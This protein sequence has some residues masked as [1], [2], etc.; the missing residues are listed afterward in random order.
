MRQVF[1]LILGISMLCMIP[2][3]KRYR[4]RFGMA[5][6]MLVFGAVAGCAG[7]PPGPNSGSGSI[8]ITGTGTGAAA[9]ITHSYTVNL[10]ISK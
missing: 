4:T 7:G 2:M 8:T 6:A 10:T 1:F 3:R 5:A 9:G